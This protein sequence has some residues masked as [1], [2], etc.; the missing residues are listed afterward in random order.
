MRARVLVPCETVWDRRQ[1]AAARPHWEQ[2]FEVEFLPPADADVP[3]DLDVLG[4]L[5][6]VAR[7]RRGTVQGVFSASDYPGAT[8]AGALSTALGTPGCPPARLLRAAHK[9]ASR[10][11]QREIV[12][13]AV[14]AFAL[15]DP[16]RPE[17]WNPSCGFPCFVKPVKGSFSQ[18]ARRV[19]DRADLE[20]FLGS[21]AVRAF[22]EQWMEIFDR[23]IGRFTALSVGGR[24]FMAEALLEGPQATVEGFCRGSEVHVLGVVDSSFHP[25]TRSFSSFD[26]PSALPDEIQRRMT[27]TVRRLVRHLGLVDTFFN[28][29]LAWDPLADRVSILEINPRIAGQFGDLYQKVDGL[30]AYEIA[31]ALCT[32]TPLPPRRPGRYACAASVPLR[33]FEPTRVA[34]V[35]TP[36]DVAAAEA[37]A[38]DA[39]VWIEVESGQEF[40]EF[41]SEED[42]GSV[43][44]AVMNVGGASRAEI[45]EVS[46]AMSARLGFT[47]ERLAPR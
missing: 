5:E 28:V 36:A 37:L 22:L 31:L 27:T 4:F 15:I 18:L 42:G 11:A 9:L 1:L 40:G 39:N 33:R 8:L 16:V 24:A 6:R 43:R 12:P 45:A 29:E 7:E 35:P 30:N 46:A 2:R 14:P 47:W 32:G 13:G 3:W 23:L 41:L 34:R 20:A 26:Y 44:Y 19:E 17:T 10:E 25:G 21:P 38:P